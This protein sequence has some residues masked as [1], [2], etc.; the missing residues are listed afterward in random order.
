MR[1]ARIVILD[2]QP[3]NVCL[4]ERLLGRLGYGNLTG[5]TDSAQAVALCEADPPDLLLLDLQMP[6]PDGYEVMRRLE[7]LTRGGTRLPIIVLT[8]DATTEVRPRALAAG[9]RDVVTKPFDPTEVGLR[10]ASLLETRALQL[11]LQEHQVTL[12]EQV[13]E[14]TADLELARAETL[15]CLVLAAEFRDDNTN[16]HANRVG[17]TAGLLA[18]QLGRPPEEVELITRAAP[19]HDIG[20]IG[21]SDSILLKPGRLTA[22]EFEVMK[23]HA[24][25]GAQILEGS[26]FAVLALSAVIAATHHERWDG[27][28]YPAGL[29][30][31]EITLVG[32]ITGLADVF[33]ALT[34]DRPYK[35]A[36]PIE[37]A[38][39]EIRRLDGLHFDPA[40]A[41]AFASL[42]HRAIVTGDHR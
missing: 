42:D 40:V 15:E 34:H 27:G 26:S 23:T 4:L 7:P 17:R 13:R 36:W 30:G 21:I 33:D 29:A 24:L 16:E 38:V 2:D 1:D 3:V 9:A 19:L 11:E 25:I 22:D 39:T 5:L 8:A 14:R 6:D 37:D 10:V 12:E 18:R 35:S 32:R 31:E 28:G 41:A 20:K